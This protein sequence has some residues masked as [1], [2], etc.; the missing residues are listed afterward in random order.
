MIASWATCATLAGVS[1]ATTV[2]PE[3]PDPRDR[4]VK[5]WKGTMAAVEGGARRP[6]EKRSGPVAEEAA[7]DLAVRCVN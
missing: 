3:R 5:R 4:G 6:R 2:D 7:R 1:Y